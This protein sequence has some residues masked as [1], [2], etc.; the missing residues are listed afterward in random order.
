MKKTNKITAAL[1][2]VMISG[3][4]Y[5]SDVNV[6]SF[7]PGKTIVQNGDMVSYNGECFVAKNNP[8]VWESP[9]V[10][11][12]FWDAAE[13]SGEPNPNPNPEPE[14]EPE[15]EPNPNP[16][17]GGI[18]PFIPGTTQ[19]K[20]GDVVSY[21]GQCFIAQNNPGLW[22]APSAS[23]WFWALTECSGEPS[24]E[25]DVTEVSILSPVASQLLKVNEAIVIKVRIDGESATKVE[26][27]VNNTKLAEKAID[28]SNLLYS[29]A[30]TP[31]EAGSAAINIFVFDKNN[32]K[33]EQKSVSVK[34]EAEGNDDFTAPVVTFTS[35]TNGS[36]VNKTDTVSISINAS[37]ADKDLT[38]LVVNANNQQICT[39]DAAVANTFSC[40]WQPTQTGSVTL[41]AI[42]TDAQ[43]LS[44]STSLSITVKE[45]TIEPPVT[46]P[47]GLCEEFNVYPDWT[48]GDHATTG[49]IMVNNNIAYS[50]IYWTQSKPGSDSTWA[51]HLNCDGSEPGTA[52]LL[53][54]PNPM[55]PVRLEVAGWPNTFVVASPSLTAPATLTIET[56]NSADLADVDK[57]TATFVS[58]IEMAAQ[59]SSS[60]IIIN[61]D[62]LDKATQDKGLSSEKIAVKE[63]LI[64]AVDSTG[65]KIDI[66]A[67]N[68]LSNDLKGWAQAHNLI[69]S[70]L[71]PEATFGWSLS[72]GDFAYN[73]HSGRQSVWNAASNY[74][75]ELLNKL[76]LYKA[77]SATKADFISFTK[78]E[79][80]A[81]LSNE[82]WHNALEYV[83]Q[84]TDY[85]KVPAMLA[86]MPTDQA[87][88]Y[89]MGDSSHKAQI[90][91]AAFSNIFAILFNKDTATLTDKIEQYQAVKVPL[92]YVGEELEKGS[93]TRIEAL[94]KELA[95]AENVMDNE[96]FL[97]ETPQ[98]Q[99]IP[100][101]V[102]KWNDFLDGLNAMHNIGVA[103]NKFWLLNDEADDA[104]NITYAK[105]AIAAFLAQSMQETIR[106]NACD[107]NNW[108]EVKYGAP[109]DYPMSASCGQLGQKYADYGVNPDSGLDYAYSCPRDNKMEVSALT[110]AKWYGAPAPVFAAPNAVL[111]ERGLL[112][113]GHVGRWT[114]SGHCNDVPENVDTSKQV[115]ER[116][117]CKTY[118]GQKA[119][120]FLW[121]GSSQESVEGCGW[122]GRGV[123]QTTGRQNFGT[124]NHYLGRSHVDPATIGKTID[125]VTV[126][127][128]PANPL[129][130][131]L[132]L[133]SN[134]GL[135]CSSEENK[136]I[137]WI[138]GLFYW[139]TSVQEYS[140]E[141]GQ[142]ADWNYYNEI[143]KY[144]DGGLKGT[145]FID[146]VSG[147]VNRGCPDTVCESGEVHNVKE[148]QANFKLV[149]EKLGVKAQL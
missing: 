105:V 147:I 45:E 121:D 97:Y 63:A 139:V 100:S 90:R 5:A 108:S 77:D 101:T 115:W 26:F 125:G 10:D 25:P 117:E 131:D 103:G 120:T 91:K 87:A 134:P 109:A 128:P 75:A 3:N 52:P 16:D 64:K 80:T 57:L 119:G 2:S 12:W 130:A 18:I 85:A 133:C 137:K 84:V 138:A 22:E 111:E 68:A 39:F 113:N 62:V 114:N 56:S 20:N 44:S 141:G 58:M 93:L 36:T 89:F 136:E 88:N 72:I 27:W 9:S 76:A 135:I 82:Q 142:Y 112:V 15:P 32:Q 106:Y 42:A 145:Q 110:H 74:T 43:A 48:R 61:S 28:Q 7:V 123:I 83:K 81:M 67:I 140:N 104:T 41:S 35:P 54:L 1:F 148:R 78:P 65:S 47:G 143:K 4:A 49:D 122:W 149:L 146:D 34:V 31:S 124:L 11:S 38:T 92:Y 37:D 59:A 126:E 53:S 96:A 13:C 66:D 60:S 33:I 102:Y 70:T 17:L 118:V 129:Y 19:V 116:D 21:D 127:A 8:G 29:Q 132:D 46:P 107:E 51:L 30:W 99:W 69:I 94:N 40:D 71:A 144:V 98:S 24:P 79:T 50:A 23:S 86:D 55:D 95:N 6:V 14:P 73:P